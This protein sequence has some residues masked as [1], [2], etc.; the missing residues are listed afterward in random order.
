MCLTVAF[1][2]RF[3]VIT[4]RK[5]IRYFLFVTCIR[6]DNDYGDFF[7]TYKSK[8]MTLFFETYDFV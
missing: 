7:M 1:E 6:L 5:V 8:N 3:Q 2:Q 4:L